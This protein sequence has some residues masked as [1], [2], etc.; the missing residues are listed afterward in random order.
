M[1]DKNKIR[2]LLYDLNVTYHN[3]D[4]GRMVRNKITV[5]DDGTVDVIGNIKMSNKG[6][7][8]LPV[9][10]RRITGDFDCSINNINTTKGFPK[11][12]TGHFSCERN[13]LTSLVGCPV[14][15]GGEYDCSEN[16]LT[17]LV[18]CPQQI[19][20]SF[21]CN[22]NKIHTLEHCPIDIG[23]DFNCNE[24][25]ISS[26][27]KMPKR[28]GGDFYISSNPMPEFIEI[29]NTLEWEERQILF[30]YQSHYDVW[31]PLFDK[32]AMLDLVADI[33]DGLE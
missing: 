1:I 7:T 3:D 11:V 30:K 21:S 15:V 5:N 8:E 6:Y 4:W 9:T 27:F 22:D 32:Q 17:S 19:T 2:S 23:E 24:N 20:Y 29:Y 33:K 14:I 16:K 10:F 13:D 28:I 26:L 25:R 12:V 18:G 31:T